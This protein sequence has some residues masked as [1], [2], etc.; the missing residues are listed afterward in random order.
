MVSDQKL[1]DDDGDELCELRFCTAINLACGDGVGNE[2]E[3]SMRVVMI[4]CL[5]AK[6]GKKLWGFKLCFEWMCYD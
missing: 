3:E 6:C 1:L 4:F 2:D 5:V